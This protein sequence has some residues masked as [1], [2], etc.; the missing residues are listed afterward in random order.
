L[1]DVGYTGT[2]D[3]ELK[4]NAQFKFIIKPVTYT[5][6]TEVVVKDVDENLDILDNGA[7]IGN[8]RDGAIN[9]VASSYT[10]TYNGTTKELNIILSTLNNT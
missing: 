3:Y 8:L 9:N 10:I 7:V 5:G 6:E 4:D 2:L 1:K